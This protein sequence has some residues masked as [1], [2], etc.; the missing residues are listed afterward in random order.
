[1]KKIIFIALFFF[2]TTSFSQGNL[3]FNQVISETG[4]LANQSTGS[5]ILTVPV[6]K[7][8]KIESLL[9]SSYSSVYIKINNLPMDCYATYYA[10]QFPFWLS[11]NKTIQIQS[12]SSNPIN[13][14]ISIIEFNIIP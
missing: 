3:Q 5:T 8:W 12:T 6:G 1:M 9:S 14:F 7:V 13:Y 2:L 10:M 4:I 11:S